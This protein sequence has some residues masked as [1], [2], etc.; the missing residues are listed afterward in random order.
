MNSTIKLNSRPTARPQPA[1]APAAV[2][3]RSLL[4]PVDF[5]AVAHKAVEYA[6]ALARNVGAKVTFIHVI[7]PIAVPDFAAYYA[8]PD[9]EELAS[10]S[11]ERLGELAA[12]L[13][14]DRR[15]REHTIVRHGVVYQEIIRAADSIKADLIILSTHG[16]SGI[17]HVLLGSTA[18]RV[19]RHSHCP[20]LVVPVHS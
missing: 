17:K 1:T 8:L 18:E 10:R 20:V 9:A 14:F 3:L 7:E 19:V 4:V 6:A 5:S 2:Q 16:Y 12:K 11:Q 13:G 15:S